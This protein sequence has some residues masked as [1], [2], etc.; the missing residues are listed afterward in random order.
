VRTSGTQAAELLLYT[1]ATLKSTN[2]R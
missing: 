2:H 1:Q